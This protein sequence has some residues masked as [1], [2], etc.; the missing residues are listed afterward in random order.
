[1]QGASGRRRVELHGGC[2][3]GLV[4]LAAVWLHVSITP[5]AP[6]TAAPATHGL[7]HGG[8]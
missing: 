1:M 8:E 6:P 4:A 2:R 5:L 7:P 3:P